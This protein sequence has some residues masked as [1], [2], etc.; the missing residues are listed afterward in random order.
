MR[1]AKHSSPCGGVKQGKERV[2]NDLLLVRPQKKVIEKETVAVVVVDFLRSLLRA[3]S[4]LSWA[5]FPDGPKWGKELGECSLSVLKRATI[6][7]SRCEKLM[8]IEMRVDL[9][10][11]ETGHMEERKS[12]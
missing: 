9:M 8:T 10:K 11:R 3:T 12:L 7:A 5:Y 1:Q 6:I 2:W 4:G